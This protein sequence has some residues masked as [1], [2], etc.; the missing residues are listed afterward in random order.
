MHGLV[1]EPHVL[2]QHLVHKHQIAQ[3][4]RHLLALRNCAK[5]KLDSL[6]RGAVAFGHSFF[7]LT[8]NYQCKN[9]MLIDNK[10]RK[11]RVCKTALASQPATRYSAW[12]QTNTPHQ[13]TENDDDLGTDSAHRRKLMDTSLPCVAAAPFNGFASR[14]WPKIGGRPACFFAE[15]VFPKRADVGQLSGTHLYLFG[16]YESGSW[17]G[18]PIKI[19]CFAVVEHR[20]DAKPATQ[21]LLQDDNVFFASKIERAR[22]AALP[23]S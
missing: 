3:A 1:K 7:C 16:G 10:A 18:Q 9:A 4:H 23:K 21:H 14:D 2:R 13:A 15:M 5:A 8:I 12:C 22:L 19:P 20:A 17:K 6:F 11:L